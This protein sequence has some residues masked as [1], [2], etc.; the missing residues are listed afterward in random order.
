MKN[1]PLTLAS[2]LIFGFVAINPYAGATVLI[3]FPYQT[4]QLI[5]CEIKPAL[6][7]ALFGALYLAGAAMLGW[8]TYR[9]S[10]EEARFLV[11]ILV[12][13]GIL[14]SMVTLIHI[15]RFTPGFMS[16]YWLVI[17][18]GA[19]MLAVW[20]YVQ[21]ERRGANWFVHEPIL[22][23]TQLLAGTTGLTLL[24]VGIGIL[25]WPHFAVANWPWPIAALMVRIF[26]A[27][28]SAF[29]V[30]LLWF[31]I[32]RDWHRLRYLP[33][34]MMAAAGADLLMLMRHAGDL[35]DFGFRLW[36][37]IGHLALFGLIGWGLYRLQTSARKPSPM[38][39]V[40]A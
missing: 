14:I 29:G 28:F 35:T 20:V 40:R 31:L 23:V 2:R 25:I 17:Y 15:E 36:L 21:Q 3:I 24:I 11:P 5:F 33:T 18:I 16:F 10:W 7:A 19:P 34:L 38:S 37:Y 30:G 26:A 8:V 9:G 32:D 1:N 27:W 39:S 12:S 4:D 22:P 13:A 6:S